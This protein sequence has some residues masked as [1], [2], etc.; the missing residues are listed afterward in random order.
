[1]RQQQ[2]LAWLSTVRRSCMLSW[3]RLLLLLLLQLESGNHRSLLRVCL[4]LHLSWKIIGERWWKNDPY[5]YEQTAEWAWS[6]YTY[7]VR[8]FLGFFI[9]PHP[10][11]HDFCTEN[12]QY[13]GYFL[14][15]PAPAPQYMYA[16]LP[17]WPWSSTLCGLSCNTDGAAFAAFA[18]FAAGSVGWF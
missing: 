4:Y 12:T 13:F 2:I 3:A 15:P 8:N 18:A 14:T 16:P 5:L 10:F 11:N 6:R 1:M 17:C 9:P 7:D